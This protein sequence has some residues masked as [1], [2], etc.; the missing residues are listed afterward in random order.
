MP[1]KQQQDRAAET[2]DESNIGSHSS[3]S[4]KDTTDCSSVSDIEPD[5]DDSTE[6][7]TEANDQVS[8]ES[9]SR[10]HEDSFVPRG[11][12]RQ[13]TFQNCPQMHFVDANKVF[14]PMT[15]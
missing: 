15:F 10:I 13:F 3:D 4:Y 7:P 11:L 8:Y 12:Y 5:S 9:K 6:V 14:K 1:L 2:D